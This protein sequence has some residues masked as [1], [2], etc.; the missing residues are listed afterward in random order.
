MAGATVLIPAA[1]MFRT[2]FAPT[3]W[4]INVPKAS[5]TR[6]GLAPSVSLSA[7]VVVPKITVQRTMLVPTVGAIVNDTATATVTVSML[8]RRFNITK[9]EVSVSG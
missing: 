7:L 3:V 8:P 6:S 4:P 2:G 9:S 1:Q 5:I